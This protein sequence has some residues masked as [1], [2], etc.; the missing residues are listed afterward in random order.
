MFITVIILILAQ[1]CGKHGP[2]KNLL[3]SDLISHDIARQGYDTFWKVDGNMWTTVVSRYPVKKNAI[4]KVTFFMLC[5]GAFFIGC[6]PNTKV[7]WNQHV[8]QIGETVA[9]FTENG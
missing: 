1:A 5:G 2:K 8:G 4:T 9:Y 6:G 3:F 7:Q